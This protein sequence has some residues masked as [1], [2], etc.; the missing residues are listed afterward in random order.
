MDSPKGQAFLLL[1]AFFCLWTFG[2]GTTQFAPC[3]P[4][5]LVMRSAL[6]VPTTGDSMYNDA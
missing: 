2:G 3:L 5:L 1:L 4:I 6:R